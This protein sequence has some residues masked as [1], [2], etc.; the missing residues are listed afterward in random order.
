MNMGVN[1]LLGMLYIFLNCGDLNGPTLGGIFTIIGFSAMGKHAF[2]IVPVMIGVALGAYG[3]HQ[4]LDYPSLQLAGLF[5]TT[6]APISGHFGWPFGVLAGFIHSA[7]VLQI[8]SPVAGVNLYNCGFSGALVGIV[9]Y[10]IITAV[11]VHRRPK[12][13]DEDYYDLFEGDSPIDTSDWRTTRTV[14]SEQ[15]E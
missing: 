14:V 6:L 10:P 3:I 15:A 9:L 5:G 11:W 2:N 12:L 8:S 1:G 13:R 4:T 7:L